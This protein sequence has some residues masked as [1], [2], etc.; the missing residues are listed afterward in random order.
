MNQRLHL[1][2]KGFSLGFFSF[3]QT[4]VLIFVERL[5]I[6]LGFHFQCSAVMHHSLTRYSNGLLF[7]VTSSVRDYNSE[8]QYLHY[9][10]SSE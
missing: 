10:Y 9:S 2:L 5:F 8:I 1:L 4:Y 7:S 6:D 3:V